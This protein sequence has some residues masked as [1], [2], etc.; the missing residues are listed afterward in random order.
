M[1]HETLACYSNILPTHHQQA[2]IYQS[3]VPVMKR[4]VPMMLAWSTE[5]PPTD[6]AAPLAPKPLAPSP[7]PDSLAAL[8]P[9]PQPADDVPSAASAALRLA[10]RFWFFLD[11]LPPPAAGNGQQQQ[12]QQHSM[13]RQVHE[14]A[15]T[16]DPVG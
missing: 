9:C 6:P 8:L 7:T 10:A 14:L 4:P 1:L 16:S 2:A 11:A 5:V 15:L 12:Q 3:D 13:V